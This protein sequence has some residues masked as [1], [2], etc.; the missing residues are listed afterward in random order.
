MFVPIENMALKNL[1]DSDKIYIFVACHT[2][3]LYVCTIA[4]AMSLFTAFQRHVAQ[5]A[6][7]RCKDLL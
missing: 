4:T 3:H 6:E 1:P 7:S 2:L 5:I